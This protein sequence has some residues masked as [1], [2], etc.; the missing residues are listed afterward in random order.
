MV[1]LYLCSFVIRYVGILVVGLYEKWSR[2]ELCWV[3]FK[4]I[5]LVVDLVFKEL[6]CYVTRVLSFY[7][8]CLY[9]GGYSWEACCSLCL[10]GGIGWIA[11]VIWDVWGSW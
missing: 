8:W 10:V 2:L 4:K 6:K 11:R 9:I 7:Y 3:K 5:N 1:L